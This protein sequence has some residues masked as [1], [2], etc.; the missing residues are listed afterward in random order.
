MK[1]R[2]RKTK[3]K[4]P[5]LFVTFEGGEGVGKS[6]LIQALS[7]YVS[8]QTK[9]TSLTTRE[10]GGTPFAEKLRQTLVGVEELD[11]WTETLLYSAA[12]SNHMSA[13]IIPA[14]KRGEIVLCDRF[15]DSTLA[16]QGAGR[17]LPETELKKLNKIA[18]HGYAPDLT[19]LLDSDPK[20]TLQKSTVQ[21]KFEKAPMSF[22]QKVRNKFIE[23]AKKER[24][25]FLVIRAHS[26]PPQA[27]AEY[28]FKNY[29]IKRLAK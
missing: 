17:G 29:I 11:S 26:M 6:T 16:Y 3:R 19:I 9:L 2:A 10:P 23:L 8:S 12:R 22:H 15:Y 5:G 7:E 4:Y 27:M 14:L 1:P 24:K 25:R 21:N 13:K 28:V 18:S 20:K